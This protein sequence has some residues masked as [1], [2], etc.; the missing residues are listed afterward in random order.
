MDAKTVLSPRPAHDVV[1]VSDGAAWIGAFRCPD[2]GAVAA[3]QTLGCRRCASR[4]A[5]Q[6]FRASERGRVY[7]WSVVE[8]SYPGVAVPFV[9]VIVDL[10]DGLTLKGTLCDVDVD[11]VRGGMPVTLVFD[12]AG[13]ARDAS[14][15]PFVGYHFEAASGD[16]K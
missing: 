3:E 15:A 4:T 9:S 8:R 13:G 2:C 5:P 1:R 14:G 12:D 16:S 6:S 11:S 7:A 10:S